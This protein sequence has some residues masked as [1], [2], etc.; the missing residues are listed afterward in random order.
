[1]LHM[2]PMTLQTLNSAVDTRQWAQ[3]QKEPSDAGR[4]NE[5]ATPSRED[6]QR[7]SQTST[8]ETARHGET[9]ER[10]RSAR[11]SERLVGNQ[12][13][14]FVGTMRD[15][16]RARHGLAPLREHPNTSSPVFGSQIRFFAGAV[17]RL[18]HRETLDGDRAHFGI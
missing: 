5:D 8:P 6:E 14:F 10:G 3:T 4:A 2:S 18:R 12:I 16:A 7:Y 15:V 11:H 17:R 9:G 13:S 1:M